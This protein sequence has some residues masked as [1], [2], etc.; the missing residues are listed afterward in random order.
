MAAPDQITVSVAQ[1]Q[2]LQRI[3]AFA[4][5]PQ[6]IR[7]L[8]ADPEPL[9]VKAG[10][11]PDAL[12]DP[13]RR[14]PY[15]AIGDLL[16]IA[17]HR[18]HCAHIGLLVGRM[19]HLSDL[20]LVGELV[21]NSRTVADALDTLTVYQHLNSGGGLAFLLAR[22]S[23]VDLGYAVYVPGIPGTEYIYDAVL[24]AGMN[25]VRELCGPAWQPSDVLIPHAKPMDVT[26]YHSMFKAEPRFNAEMCALR[27]P[28]S[29][30][31]R[32]VEGADPQRRRNA[33]LRAEQ[34]GRGQIVDQVSRALRAVLL[35]GKNSGD[36]V[37]EMLAMHRRTMN[38]R[39]KAEGT[40][41]QEV[42]DTVRFEVARQLLRDSTLALDDVAA[43]LGYA[44]VTPFMH[45][46][47]RWAG[48]TPDRWRRAAAAE[49]HDERGA[50][51]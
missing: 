2:P 13:E 17:A 18:T 22:D 7:E 10:L 36:D 39:L 1:P 19:W 25:Y 12:H 33:E 8:G 45:T 27:F 48:T 50:D 15:A 3:G 51:P 46:F 32:T 41:F 40:T 23:S 37:A 5:V 26:P 11:D 24:A 44:G 21:A 34:V 43:T 29:W 16:R 28:A 9:L 4:E 14:V 31:A 6:L 35:H 47:R 42:L 49:R 38:R 20:G 30:M